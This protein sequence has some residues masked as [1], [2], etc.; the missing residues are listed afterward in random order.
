M[1]KTSLALIAIVLL[2]AVIYYKLG[3]RSFTSS[4]SSHALATGSHAVAPEFSLQ[5]LDG[6]PL[7]LQSYRGKVVLLDFWATWCAPCRT[8]I[9]HFVK[10]Q[11][12]YSDQGLQI[13][14]ISMD[15]GAKPVRQ[16]YQEFKMNYPVAVGNEQVAEA[17]GGVLGLPVTFLIGRDGRIAAKFTGAVEIATLEQAIQAELA[18]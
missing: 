3:R 9:P 5:D 15:D 1:R 12:Q 16:F 6:K 18:K 2:V 13:I 7:D 11:S 10:L 8:E 14:G 17:Y 4:R